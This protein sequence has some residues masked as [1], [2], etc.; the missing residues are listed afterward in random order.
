MVG[1]ICE[2]KEMESA[3]VWKHER[4]K[5]HGVRKAK[6]HFTYGRKFLEIKRQRMASPLPDH[7]GLHTTF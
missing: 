1:K 3:K 6:E 7:K 2:A 5:C 4:T